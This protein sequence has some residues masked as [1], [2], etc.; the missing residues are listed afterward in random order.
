MRLTA[1]AIRAVD[2]L[3]YEDVEVP[4]WGGSVIVRGL[5]AKERDNYDREIIRV[6]NHGNTSLG[7]LENL[8]ALLVV[9]CLVN[10]DHT[11]MYRDADAKW[12]GEK[13]SKVI[14]EL[15]DVAARLSG[16][17]A[18]EVEEVAADLDGDQPDSNSSE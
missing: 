5:T 2:D 14:G 1:D 11:R 17:R 10:E 9:R 7:R 3:V 13:S 18:E 12:L 16:M 4:E 6:D 15:Y 8:R